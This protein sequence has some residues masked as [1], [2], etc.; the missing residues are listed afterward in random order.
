MIKY[1]VEGIDPD[2]RAGNNLSLRAVFAGLVTFL[3]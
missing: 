3:A 2:E 1:F